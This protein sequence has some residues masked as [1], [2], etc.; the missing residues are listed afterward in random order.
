MTQ[1]NSI[2]AERDAYALLSRSDTITDTLVVDPI[3]QGVCEKFLLPNG[4]FGYQIHV[5]AALEVGRELENRHCIVKKTRLPF[6]FAPSQSYCREHVG[7][8]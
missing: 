7:D 1:R 8:D 3:T 5:T 2:Q 4:E 6:F